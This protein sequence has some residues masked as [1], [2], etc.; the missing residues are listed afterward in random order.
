M[1]QKLRYKYYL[2]AKKI[3][4]TR[5]FLRMSFFFCNFAVGLDMT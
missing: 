3:P 2:L 1:L 5:F 4:K